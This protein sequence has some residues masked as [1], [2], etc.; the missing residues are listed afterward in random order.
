MIPDDTF[1]YK[2]FTGIIEVDNSH[3]QTRYI[4]KSYKLPYP[5]SS[6]SIEQLKKDVTQ[7]I[8]QQLSCKEQQDNIPLTE[9]EASRLKKKLENRGTLNTLIRT[10]VKE[11]YLGTNNSC[12]T[13]K[14]ICMGVDIIREYLVGDIIKDISRCFINSY[15]TI[16]YIPILIANEKELSEY[17][18][19]DISDKVNGL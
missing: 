4:M 12:L 5:F 11:R 17:E 13:Y 18:R 19:K 6:D 8:D 1:S 14:E 7:Y 16:F 10:L 15:N 9:N 3:W 2:N